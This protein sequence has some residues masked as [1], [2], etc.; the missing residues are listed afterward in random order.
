MLV[1]RVIQKCKCLKDGV[2]TYMAVVKEQMVKRNTP[3]DSWARTCHLRSFGVFI[4]KHNIRGLVVTLLPVLRMHVA[5]SHTKC[6][7]LR[8]VLKGLPGLLKE[9]S[10][11]NSEEA[12]ALRAS[13]LTFQGEVYALDDKWVLSGLGHKYGVDIEAVKNARVLHFNGKMKP[14]LE[15]GIRDYTV[16]WRKFLNQENHGSG[17]Y[18]V[19]FTAIKVDFENKRPDPLSIPDTITFAASGP[20]PVF[21][22]SRCLAQNVLKHDGGKIDWVERR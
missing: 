10:E 2:K 4:L 20:P 17:S 11:M 21:L 9:A 12:V 5:G 15:L 13:L 7:A 6:T 3:Y 16:F 1:K 8:S 18:K 22:V 14:W 19:A